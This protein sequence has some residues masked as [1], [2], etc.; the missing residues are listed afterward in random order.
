MRTITLELVRHGPAH[1]Q[2]I[3]PLAQYL[4]LCE[5]HPA[6]TLRLPLEHNQ[7]LYRLSALSYRA[8]K[9]AREF[10][11]RDTAALL[12]ELFARIPGLT[13]DMNRRDRQSAD[14]ARPDRQSTDVSRPDPQSI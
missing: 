10:Q 13:A 14:S 3:S 5:N 9:Q 4:A 6:V 12:G 1:N 8:G 7:V 2:L 11:L